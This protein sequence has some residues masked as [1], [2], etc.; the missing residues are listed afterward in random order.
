MTFAEPKKN[1]MYACKFFPHQLFL[2][3]F[4]HKTG[5]FGVFFGQKLGILP[6]VGECLSFLLSEVVF[7]AASIP[8][9]EGGYVPAKKPSVS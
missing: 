5:V 4:T 8:I 2:H 9:S 6:L 1:T 3:Q 7:S